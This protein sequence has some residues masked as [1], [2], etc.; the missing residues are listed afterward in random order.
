M[1]KT[2]DKTGNWKVQGLWE[3]EDLH[4]SSASIAKFTD[5]TSLSFHICN[6]IN[7]CSPCGLIRLHVTGGLLCR[8]RCVT[9]RENCY[10]A[11]GFLRTKLKIAIPSLDRAGIVMK[12]SVWNLRSWE[13]LTSIYRYVYALFIFLTTIKFR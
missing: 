7:L 8:V 4:F 2:S 12:S 11:R 1:L 9:D 6:F 5:L 13:F 3:S 10:P